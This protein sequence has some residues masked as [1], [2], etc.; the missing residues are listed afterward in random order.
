[1]TT[2]KNAM[3][4]GPSD[5]RCGRGR[6]DAGNTR[7]AR[8]FLKRK[9][10]APRFKGLFGPGRGHVSYDPALPPRGGIAQLG[11]NYDSA[12]PTSPVMST[13]NAMSGY[14]GCAQ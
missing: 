4:R 6:P 14:H 7:F 5:P 8:F 10:R 1:V 12:L 11:A 9:A 3:F 2:E 13:G